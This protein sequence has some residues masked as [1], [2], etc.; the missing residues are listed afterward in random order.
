[1]EID[2]PDGFSYII[3][4]NHC[5]KSHQQLPLFDLLCQNS[6]NLKDVEFFPSKA[7]KDEY[8]LKIQTNLEPELTTTL[9][10]LNITYVK[11]QNRTKFF[12]TNVPTT[13]SDNDLTK[14]LQAQY[15][16]ASFQ[17]FSRKRNLAF[18]SIPTSI[19]K[20]CP[21][22]TKANI[23]TK[24]TPLIL[25]SCP[26]LY[27]RPYTPKFKRAHV[28]SSNQNSSH[29]L[30]YAEVMSQAQDKIIEKTDS[31]IQEIKNQ[32]SSH[33]EIIEENKTTM[34]EMKKQTQTLMERV[35]N[36]EN[37]NT[38]INDQL[39]TLTTNVNNL[40]TTLT[41]QFQKL[42]TIAPAVNHLTQH[43]NSLLSVIWPQQYPQQILV[44]TP[45]QQTY[46]HQTPQHQPNPNLKRHQNALFSPIINQ[47]KVQPIVHTN[48]KQK[49][50]IDAQAYAPS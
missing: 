42:S 14:L 29:Q 19:A 22:L 49:T 28:K 8:C 34:Q 15:A 31:T 39:S 13:L 23:S 37:E 20:Q 40:T 18:I 41:T 30:S 48:K 33:M 11:S 3:T 16:D 44:Q 38:K 25:P 27:L 12:T 2:N 45:P 47:N 10:K 32:T 46:Q 6:N 7:M 9:S 4:T 26:P 50:T 21:L 36:L 5:R 24:G 1:M 35:S 17:R 43:V